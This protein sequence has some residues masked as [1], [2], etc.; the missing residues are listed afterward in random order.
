LFTASVLPIA[1]CVTIPARLAVWNT[2][3]LRTIGDLRSWKTDHS[4]R[5][6]HSG[7]SFF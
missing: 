3:L 6:K 1:T 4:L 2:A 5:K 7:F